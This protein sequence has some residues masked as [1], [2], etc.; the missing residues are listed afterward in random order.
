MKYQVPVLEIVP[1]DFSIDTLTASVQGDGAHYNFS[2]IMN[3]LNPP[4][5][6]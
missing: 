2:D 3:E 4:S 5:A 1:C 6:T